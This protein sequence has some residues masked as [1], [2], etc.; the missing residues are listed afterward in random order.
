MTLLRQLGC[1]AVQ[2]A[3][4]RR[5]LLCRQFSVFRHSGALPASLPS[6]LQELIGPDVP[7]GGLGEQEMIERLSTGYCAGSPSI[8]STKLSSKKSTGGFGLPARPQGFRTSPLL[9][10]R[11]EGGWPYPTS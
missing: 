2:K 9:M 11:P 6:G 3:L 5:C 10:R 8:R 1:G 4:E 7:L